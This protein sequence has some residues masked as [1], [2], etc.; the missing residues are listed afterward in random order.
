MNKVRKFGT[1]FL[2]L[3]LLAMMVATTSMAASTPITITSSPGQSNRSDNLAIPSGRT[4][5]AS[6]KLN[7]TSYNRKFPKIIPV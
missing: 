7:T 5:N 3:T 1:L 4:V 6:I 2:A